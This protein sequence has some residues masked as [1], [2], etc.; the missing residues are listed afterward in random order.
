MAAGVRY[1]ALVDHVSD[2]D[3]LDIAAALERMETEAYPSPTVLFEHLDE[4]GVQ[5]GAVRAGI[6]LGLEAL[7]T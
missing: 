7:D 1:Q 3:L 4:E 5:G 2:A 6:N